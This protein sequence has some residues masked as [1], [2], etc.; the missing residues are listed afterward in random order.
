MENKQNKKFQS[1]SDFSITYRSIYELGK[2]P[3]DDAGL[4]YENSVSSFLED[5]GII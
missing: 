4:V 3:S 1:M 2:Q 5:G